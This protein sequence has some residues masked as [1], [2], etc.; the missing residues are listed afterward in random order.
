[1]S[2]VKTADGKRMLLAAR[3]S[4]PVFDAV[5]AARGDK[6]QSAWVRDAVLAALAAHGAHV[7][8]P[9]E[10]VKKRARPRVAEPVEQRPASRVGP[11]GLLTPAPR[12]KVPPRPD[13]PLGAGVFREPGGVETTTFIPPA[14]AKN[15]TRC[16]HPGIRTVG[17]NLGTCPDCGHRVE[18]GGLWAP[19]CDAGTCTHK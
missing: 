10:P 19:E 2:R 16:T 12:P 3:V 13:R 1:M 18:P 11:D 14:P 5:Q 17:S 4:Q 15:R 8:T 7:E 9:P 6:D